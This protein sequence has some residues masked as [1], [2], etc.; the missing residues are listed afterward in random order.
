MGA[1]AACLW[2]VSVVALTQEDIPVP[3]PI[4]GSHR[5]HSH[6]AGHPSAPLS[7]GNGWIS[8][9]VCFIIITD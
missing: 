3:A 6:L 1:E 7:L 9:D 4:P 5:E 2:C 8:A